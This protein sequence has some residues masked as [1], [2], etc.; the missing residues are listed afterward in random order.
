MA[1]ACW[2]EAGAEQCHIKQQQQQLQDSQ[3]R[4]GWL[5][6]CLLDTGKALYW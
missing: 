3:R 1:A 5:I 4:S 2:L 6:L